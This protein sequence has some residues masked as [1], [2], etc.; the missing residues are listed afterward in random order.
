MGSKAGALKAMRHW[1]CP[2]CGKKMHVNRGGFTGHIK[3]CT[4]DHEARFWSKVDKTGSCWL[5]RGAVNTTG[6]GMFIYRGK[7]NTVAHRL[8]WR[9][10]KGPIPAG[11]L[12]LHRCDTPRCCNPDHLFLGTD[13]DNSADMYAKGRDRSRGEKNIHAR[14]TA[15][16]VREIR[17]LRLVGWNGA[18]LAARFGITASH[19]CNIWQGKSWAHLP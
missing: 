1:V 5:Y 2:H 16:I 19:A 10:L 9:L 6:Y 3:S 11:K 7:K 18:Q 14:L 17:N 12:V 15:S 13:A 8:A 4:A